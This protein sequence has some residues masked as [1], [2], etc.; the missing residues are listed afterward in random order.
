M[1][2]LTHS[3]ALQDPAIPA[4]LAE[5]ALIDARTSAAVGDMGVSWWQ[6]KVASGEAPKPAIQQP[7]MTRWRLA[8]VRAFWV[9][10]AERASNEAAERLKAQ[11]HKASTAAAARRNAVPPN[12][13]SADELEG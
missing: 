4:A 12:T 1:K 9:S 8:D 7:R 11:V 6:A 5:I 2:T 10:Y 13:N 3:E